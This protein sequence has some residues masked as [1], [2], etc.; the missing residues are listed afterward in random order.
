MIKGWV[1]RKALEKCD[2]LFED[3]S[4]PNGAV[5]LIEGEHVEVQYDGNPRD[6]ESYDD[7]K[8]ARKL[9][10]IMENEEEESFIIER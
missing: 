3:E 2:F 10:F 4:L 9:I 5:V 6:S 8:L 1:S 7:E